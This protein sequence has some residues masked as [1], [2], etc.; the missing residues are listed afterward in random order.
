MIVFIFVISNFKLSP[1]YIYQKFENT[2]YNKI[3]W[4]LQRIESGEFKKNRYKAVFFGSSQCY[5]GINDSILGQGYLNLGMNTPSRD[6]DLFMQSTFEKSG[7]KADSYY[8]VFDG[9]RLVSYGIHPLMSYLVT[10][11]WLLDHGQSLYSL[12]FWKF[13]LLRFQHIVQSVFNKSDHFKVFNRKYGV[14]YLDVNISENRKPS[15]NFKFQLTRYNDRRLVSTWDE[16]RNNIASQWNFYDSTVKIK[17][18]YLL[19][20]PGFNNNNVIE[21]QLESF[22][23][24]PGLI[25]VRSISLKDYSEFTNNNA[26]W[27]DPGHLNRVGAIKFTLKLKEML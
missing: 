8:S 15:I 12:H 4:F 26:N 27:V 16:F 6:L 13:V 3:N 7:G 9:S 20:T 23:K 5:Y 22:K 11:I 14:G 19:F 10:P 18:S 17:S 2:Q 1:N 25:E 21:K 24:I